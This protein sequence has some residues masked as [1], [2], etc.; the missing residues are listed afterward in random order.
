MELRCVASIFERQNEFLGQKNVWGDGFWGVKSKEM[1]QK[2][3]FYIRTPSEINLTKSALNS[4]RSA[5]VSDEVGFSWDKVHISC[6]IACFGVIRVGKIEHF[7]AEKRRNLCNR[8]SVSDFAKVGENA[9]FRSG[10]RFVFVHAK[11]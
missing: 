2:L 5:L 7:C 1:L 9:L 10:I 3:T 11:I 6:K 4:T 8:L